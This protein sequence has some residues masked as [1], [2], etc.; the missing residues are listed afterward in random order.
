MPTEYHIQPSPSRVAES[1]HTRSQRG[2]RQ[3]LRRRI[4]SMIARFDKIPDRSSGCHDCASYAGCF[5]R[6][7]N[8]RLKPIGTGLILAPQRR[9]KPRSCK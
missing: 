1:I 4:T 3:R 5:W 7:G 6:T 8:F 9:A 2:A